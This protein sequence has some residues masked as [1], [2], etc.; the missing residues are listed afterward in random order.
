MSSFNVLAASNVKRQYR[1]HLLGLVHLPV[2]E[3]Y[4]GCAFTQK[5]VKMSKMLLN[6]GHEVYLYGAE[7]SDAPCTEFIQTHTLSDIRQEWGDG[8]NRFDIGYDWKGWGFRHDFNKTRTK[9]TLKFNDSAAVGINARKRDDD[10]LLL[11]QGVYQKPVADMVNLWLTTE[12]GIGYRGSYTRFRAFESSYLMN[13]TYG[14][15][16]P[17][18]SINGHYWD[19]VIPN[20]FEAKDFPFVEK[21]EDYFFFIGRMIR[22][23]GVRTAAQTVEAI[24]GKL[25]LAG[26]QDPS[27]DI[28][29]LPDSSEYIGY[30]DPEKRAELMG[31]AKGVFVPTTYLEAFGG[32]NVEAQLCGTPAITTNFGVF[33]ETVV[34]GKT[35]FRCDVLQDFVNAALK[36]DELDPQEIRDHAERYL[37]DNVQWEFQKW[38]DDM[39][40]LYLSAHAIE[41]S[42]KGWGYLGD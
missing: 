27:F 2:S 8:D 12:P 5:I 38:W 33:P 42:G 41:H 6:L 11:M 37:T 18:K 30:V 25:I 31:K 1:F 35:G 20:Y 10:F 24:G 14:S 29:T 9:T 15:E 28:K 19:R 4:M 23:K 13:F 21:K 22:R 36:V 3:R 17:K 26:Q 32:V 40:Q 16:H 34:H 7:S 39:Y